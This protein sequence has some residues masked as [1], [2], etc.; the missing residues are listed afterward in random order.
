MEW[1]YDRSVDA[2]SITFIPNRES[3]RTVEPIPGTL[4]DYDS[5]GHPIAVE[6][7]DASRHFPK[8][9]LANLPLPVELISLTEAAKEIGLE[10]ATLRQQ[11][12]RKRITATKYH[13][14]WWISRKALDQYLASRAP[15]GR[16]SR[17][18]GAAAR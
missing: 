5:A 6:V 1:S 3:A 16:K 18:R 11:I 10:P 4:F 8:A 15:Q 9:A 2:L 17:R 14:E 12:L 13:R 7:L